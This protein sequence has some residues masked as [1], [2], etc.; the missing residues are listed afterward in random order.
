MEVVDQSSGAL[1]SIGDKA[2]T[3]AGKI[4]SSSERSSVSMQKVGSSI[5]GVATSAFAMYNLYDRVDDAS[6]RVDTAE[7]R[8][9]DTVNRVKFAQDDLNAAIEK[10]GPGSQQAIDA[11]TRFEG[12]SRRFSVGSG[13][14]SGSP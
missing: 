14:S 12:S 7:N 13:E 11:A 6:L 4:E 3:M 9:A 1:V 2:E 5:S 10:Y 8:L